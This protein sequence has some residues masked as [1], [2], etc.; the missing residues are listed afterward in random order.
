MTF[1]PQAECLALQ[2]ARRRQDTQEFKDRYAIRAGVEGTISQAVF[3]L[4]MR[5]TRYRDLA[6][7]HLQHILTATAINLLRVL[8]WQA[9]KPSTKTPHSAFAALVA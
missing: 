3:A 6:K 5:R 4:G 9:G 1:P 8:D 2:A 7:V